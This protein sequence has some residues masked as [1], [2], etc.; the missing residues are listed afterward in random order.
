MT[1]LVDANILIYAKFSDFPQHEAARVW[2][3]AA[4]NAPDP[5]AMPWISLM[6]FLRI[7]TNRRLFR[8]PLKV[9]EALTQVTEWAAR[10]NVW[11]PEPSER[12]GLIFS[13]LVRQSQAS[14]NLVT[15]AYLAALAREHGLTV[16]SSDSDF[17]HFED[18][19]W[20]NPLQR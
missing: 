20:Q 9:D 17:A 1:V 6:A 3:D 16:I 19:K 12:F 11:H 15:D 5:L 18:V 14:G 4:L 7:T 13:T 2:L 10:S 8:A